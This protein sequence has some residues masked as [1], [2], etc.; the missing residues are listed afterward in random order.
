MPNVGDTRS[1]NNAPDYKPRT[2]YG[3]NGLPKFRYESKKKAKQAIKR[4]SGIRTADGKPFQRDA[5]AYHCEH[6]N[7]FHIGHTQIKDTHD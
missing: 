7:Y 1:S 5:R 6:C 4:H 3:P 2:C